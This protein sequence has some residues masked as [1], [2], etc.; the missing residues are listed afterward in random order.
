MMGP[1]GEPD[2]I[3]GLVMLSAYLCVIMFVVLCVVAVIL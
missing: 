2:I 1:Y 3:T